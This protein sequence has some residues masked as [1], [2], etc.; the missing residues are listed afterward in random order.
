MNGKNFT[1]A[2]NSR[3]QNV[4][5]Y[6]KGF[7][8]NPGIKKVAVSNTMSVSISCGIILDKLRIW[9]EVFIF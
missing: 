3:P 4:L 7:F 5:Y 9:I 2:F 6:L 8:K 1:L